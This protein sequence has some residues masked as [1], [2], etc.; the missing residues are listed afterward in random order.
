MPVRRS[1]MS[2]HPGMQ[3]LCTDQPFRNAS[4]MIEE[5]FHAPEAPLPAIRAAADSLCF[6]PVMGAIAT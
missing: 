1:Y 6:P 2:F 4:I 5:S 3:E